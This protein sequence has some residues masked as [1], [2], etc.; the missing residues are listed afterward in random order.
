MLI[1]MPL[2]RA[3]VLLVAAAAGL[4]VVA[5]S[6]GDTLLRPAVSSALAQNSLLTT[7]TRAGPR[8][9]AAGERGHVIYSDDEG[10]TWQQAQVP[11]S[12]TLTG[13]YFVD[14]RH[15]WAT[16]HSGVI[17]ASGDGGATWTKQLDGL[18]VIAAVEAEAAARPEMARLAAGLRSDGPDKPFFDVFFRDLRHGTAIGAYGL[19][20]RTEDGGATWRP[21]LDLLDN[22]EMKHLYAIRAVG[23]DVYIAG[24]QGALFRSADGGASFARLQSP[25]GGSFFGLTI[26]PAG[27][28]LAYGLRGNLFLSEDRGAQWRKIEIATERSLSA[29]SVL[30]DGAIVL[31]DQAGTV[32]LSRDPAKGFRAI[33]LRQS[34]PFSSVVAARDAGAL[35]VGIRGVASLPVEQSALSAEQRQGQ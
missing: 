1:R 5:E 24:E 23:D 7:V 28:V 19:V 15:G 17:L 34:F 8:I 30:A 32:W 6:R 29:G 10:T 22:P 16:G 26:T 33:A 11:V 12:L 14:A 20:F 35:A 21:A 9:I 3:A 18:G 4:G 13:L 31:V 2:R 27:Q 25:Y